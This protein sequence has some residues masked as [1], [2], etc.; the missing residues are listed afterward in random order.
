MIKRCPACSRTYSDESISFCL[1]DGTLLSAPL[2]AAKEEPPPTEILPSTQAPVPP[3]E[4]ASPAVPT[5]TSLPGG[6]KYSPLPGSEPRSTNSQLLIWASLAIVA[7]AIIVIGGLVAFRVFK[8]RAGAVAAPTPEQLVTLNSATPVAT[9]ENSAA[10]KLSPQPTPA[11]TAGPNIGPPAAETRRSPTPSPAT[12]NADPVLFPPDRTSTPKATPVEA[13]GTGSA[14]FSP[15]DVDVKVHIL[16]KPQ[17]SYTDAARQNQ[18][19]GTVVLR[20]VFSSAGS[21]TNISVVRALPYGLSE[22][23]IAAAKQIK[24]QPAMKDGHP[25]STS[26]QLEYNFNLY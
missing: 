2:E 12:L 21:V 24:F 19:S 1:A 22:Q 6:G 23:A 14:V 13:T 7:V 5:M 26:M 18:V 11:P 4:P 15:R 17:P 25:V 16:S 8:I 9:P 20:V 10:A 3:T